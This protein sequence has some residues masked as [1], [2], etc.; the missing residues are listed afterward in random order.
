MLV[1]SQQSALALTVGWIV[2]QVF[3]GKTATDTDRW[4]SRGGEGREGREQREE[5]SEVLGEKNARHQHG[6]HTHNP[7][8]CTTAASRATAGGRNP[9]D[10]LLP[11][12]VYSR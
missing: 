4:T 11:A 12:T 5:D 6:Q 7:N 2:S 10:G 8:I 9:F 3:E 1:G